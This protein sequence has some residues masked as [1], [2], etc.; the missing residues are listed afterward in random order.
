M[1]VLS[2]FYVFTARTVKRLSD[3][4]GYLHF[5][6]YSNSLEAQ[7]LLS[8]VPKTPTPYSQIASADST[9]DVLNTLIQGKYIFQLYT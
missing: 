5:T 6:F 7:N 2:H 8:D 4:K 9:L 1:S 3:E